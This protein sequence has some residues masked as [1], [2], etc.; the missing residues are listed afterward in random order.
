[1]L[2]HSYIHVRFLPPQKK[3]DHVLE[4]KNLTAVVR[5]TGLVFGILRQYIDSFHGL[6]DRFLTL[7]GHTPARDRVVLHFLTRCKSGAA[8]GHAVFSVNSTSS[9][10]MRLSNRLNRHRH[11]TNLLVLWLGPLGPESGC[12]FSL[13]QSDTYPLRV[14]DPGG[15]VNG[16]VT[17]Y[18][19]QKQTVTTLP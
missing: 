3:H 7:N 10:T 1:M 6:V 15:Q 2:P 13:G 17:V 16:A 14:W 9:V 11:V 18:H 8:P 4:S 19:S 12:E 5:C